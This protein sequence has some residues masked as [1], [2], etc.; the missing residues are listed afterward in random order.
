[1]MSWAGHGKVVSG[2]EQFAR[3]LFA[4]DPGVSKVGR[5]FRQSDVISLN[6]MTPDK[7]LSEVGKG[8]EPNQKTITRSDYYQNRHR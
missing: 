7:T 4:L 1:M 3:E 2:H 6:R 8:P 5:H